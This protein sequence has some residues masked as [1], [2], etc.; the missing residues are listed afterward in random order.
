MCEARF[1]TSESLQKRLMRT[2]LRQFSFDPPLQERRA[3]ASIGSCL[4]QSFGFTLAA[5]VSAQFQVLGTDRAA[6]WAG[7]TSQTWQVSARQHD[8]QGKRSSFRH[9][10]AAPP[11][12]S[13][14]RPATQY[15]A[16]ARSQPTPCG[17]KL[18]S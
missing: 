7:W 17:A 15:R 6:S 4:T 1:D 14:C 10:P 8:S 18:R 5:P 13:H 2:R 12:K 9:H 11:H 16:L 3:A